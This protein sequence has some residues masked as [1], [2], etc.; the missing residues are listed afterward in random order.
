MARREKGR[1]G[2]AS[3]C[4]L[5]N[6]LEGKRAS[7]FFFFFEGFVF[8]FFFFAL[9][10]LFFFVSN[11]HFSVLTLPSPPNPLKQD[12]PYNFEPGVEHLNVWAFA[13]LPPAQLEALIEERRPRRDFDTL[14]Y[15]NPAALAS[16]PDVWHAHVLSRRRKEEKKEG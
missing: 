3:R 9:L 4:G 12:F 16:I 8:H 6:H 15:V 2:S 7:R 13:A 10:L 5:E 1:G 14:W 11:S